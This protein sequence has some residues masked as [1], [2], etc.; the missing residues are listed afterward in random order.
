MKP[1]ND[2]E[3]YR[4]KCEFGAQKPPK[5]RSKIQKILS[6]KMIGKYGQQG[7]IQDFSSGG[8]WKEIRPCHTKGGDTCQCCE[9]LFVLVA[10]RGKR[11]CRVRK[12]LRIEI[13]HALLCCSC[14]R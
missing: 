3:K 9:Q 6:K 10:H 1:K 12:T 5:M 14:Q 4:K 11:P 2:E 7:W 13:P 8:V